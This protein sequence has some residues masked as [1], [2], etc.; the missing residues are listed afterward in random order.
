VI[1]LALLAAI[2]SAP[3][4]RSVARAQI[5]TTVELARF[6]VSA[7]LDGK[8]MMPP[9]SR[10]ASAVEASMPPSK[11]LKNAR[12]YRL[13]PDAPTYLRIADVD[14]SRNGVVHFCEV[15]ARKINLSKAWP[16]LAAA[17]DPAIDRR[18]TANVDFYEID[19]PAQRFRVGLTDQYVL[20]EVY[21][22]ATALKRMKKL[23]APDRPY[24]TRTDLPY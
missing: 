4:E 10:S 15:R 1:A 3:Q 5:S 11:S 17:I 13:D 21:S 14:E 22:E 24:V 19:Y 2:S 23:V 12:Y 6:F 18:A 20:A 16:I 8:V 7:C 9:G